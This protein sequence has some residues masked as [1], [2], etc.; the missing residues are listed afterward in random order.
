MED[1][2]PRRWLPYSPKSWRGHERLPAC[3]L[4]TRRAPAR[5]RTGAERLAALEAGEKEPSRPLLLKMSK[6]YRRPLLV[7]YLAA[8][9]TTRD[10]GQ[11]FRTLTGPQRHNPELD[12]FVRDIK[13]RQ[14]IIRY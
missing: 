10:R 12:A 2:G 11:D 13:V 5:G 3:R 14:G 4:M 1:R 7:F 6:T 9:P 8:P